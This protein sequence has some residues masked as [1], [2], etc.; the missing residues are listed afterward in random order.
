MF[1]LN[2]N[3]IYPWNYEYLTFVCRIYVFIC[4][5]MC[6]CAQANKDGGSRDQQVLARSQGVHQVR[7]YCRLLYFTAGYCTP[8][9]KKSRE[10][11]LVF[12]FFVESSIFF[13]VKLCTYKQVLRY[14]HASLTSRPFRILWQTDPFDI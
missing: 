7:V 9:R 8:N 2:R 5:L 13:G 1:G 14:E 10:N 4:Y 11:F 12:P 3:Y 6:D